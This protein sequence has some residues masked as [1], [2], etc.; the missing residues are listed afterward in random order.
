MATCARHSSLCTRHPSSSA[1]SSK[2]R[3][4]SRVSFD[5]HV[6]DQR[7]RTIGKSYADRCG[8]IIQPSRAASS[9]RIT[10]SRSAED[11][12]IGGR[13]PSASAL[14]AAAFVARDLSAAH[15]H[16]GKGGEMVRRV[17]SLESR[18]D[19]SSDRSRGSQAGVQT[20]ERNP[21]RHHGSPS[22][23]GT[24]I[25]TGARLHTDMRVPLRNTP[26]R[27]VRALPW[28]APAGCLGVGDACLLCPTLQPLDV[29]LEPQPGRVARAHPPLSD[30]RRAW[31]HGHLLERHARRGDAL[32]ALA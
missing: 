15:S 21:G 25:G 8:W 32:G 11:R 29:D 6:L 13:G 30:H 14:S 1:R 28:R 27:R 19:C 20:T 31:Q 16:A 22:F 24:Q 4:R 3:P 18:S 17:R 26:C 10:R 2:A 5:D 12:E 7:R 9:N 23:R